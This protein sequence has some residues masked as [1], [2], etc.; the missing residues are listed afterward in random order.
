MQTDKRRL[1]A[2][3]DFYTYHMMTA[4]HT[5]QQMAGV[6]LLSLAVPQADVPC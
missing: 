1:H 6:R 2:V 4:V 5:C 3:L